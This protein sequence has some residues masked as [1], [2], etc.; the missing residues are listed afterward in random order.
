MRK[1]VK[2]FYVMSI[3][4]I[5]LL[6]CGDKYIYAVDN[7]RDTTNNFVNHKSVAAF[8]GGEKLT[9]WA[10]YKIG[11][12]NTD[13]AEI[14]LK[15]SDDKFEDKECF[16]VNAV[17]S[18]HSVYNWFFEMRD[19]YDVWLKK[20]NLKPLYFKNN[21]KEGSYRFMSS[22]RYNWQ[23]LKVHTNAQN[24]KRETNIDRVMDITPLSYDGVSHFYNLR[25]SD[26]NNIIKKGTDTLDMV[27]EKKIRK[28]SYR[29]VS[30]EVKS[31]PKIGKFKTIKFACVI[32]SSSGESFTDGS[33]FFIW[34]SDDKN[35]IPLYLET[36]IKVGSVKVTIKSWENLKYPLSSKIK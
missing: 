24:P 9:Y 25:S 4:S 20:D 22:Y 34:L 36:P 3:V 21:I 16:R 15:V 33:E 27:L 10:S 32:A 5:A 2:Y 23:T 18:T 26:V 12:I 1:N 6:F 28:V 14:I 17:A 30:H 11:F 19:E 35:M 8:K 31:I 29:Y 7:V 13:I